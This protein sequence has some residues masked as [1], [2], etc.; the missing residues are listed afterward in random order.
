MMATPPAVPH[1]TAPLNRR[2]ALI[3]FSGLMLGMLLAALD[4]AIVA[5]ALPTIVGDLGGLNHL[6]WMVTAYLLASTASTP[7]W[8]KLGDLYGRKRTFQGTILIFLVGSAL[9][10]LSQTMGQ[11]IAFRAVQGLGGGGLIVTAQGIVGD[12]V[13]PRQRGRYQGVFG[14]VFGLAS[15]IGPL[16]GG[17]FVDYLSWHWV[18]YVN[19]P[20]GAMA[21]LVTA[22][23]MP[24][25]TSRVAHAID[26]PGA[27]LI[28]SA[29]TCF[30]LLTTLGGS[31]YPWRST[32]I[33]L[34]ALA[35]VGLMVLFIMVERH[36]REP[37]LPLPLFGQRVFRVSSALAFVVG[38]ALLGP[39]TFLP[40]FLQVVKGDSPTA[41]GLRMLPLMLGMPVVS[42]VSGQLISRWGRYRPFPIVGTA[43]MALAL[44]LLSRLHEG[45]SAVVL[46]LSML[47][48]GLGLGMVMQ[49]LVIAV[50][51]AVDYRDLGAA[52][53]GVTFSRAIGSVFG[54]ALFGAIF[55]NH[56]DDQLRVVLA[57]QALP[58][59][60]DIRALEAQP[61]AIA[62]LPA[63]LGR[64]PDRC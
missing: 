30:I 40:L 37:V 56:L 64:V 33:I 39:V 20:I 12:I 59:G 7:L 50:Q 18:F 35:S 61:A 58:P 57:G 17:F 49:V 48:L 16:V 2:R 54:V 41:S 32:P 34:L 9:C 51:N 19:L 28:A 46:S 29:T 62:A 26:Y 1:P 53:S 11:L 24:S 3:I 14:A 5:T 63:A 52:T 43:L 22:V 36:A 45:M 4:Q 25:I 6:S 27:V 31:V 23:T 44:F 21:L 10:G 8:G 13:S 47:L 42:V 15:V 55:T 38:M 60:L